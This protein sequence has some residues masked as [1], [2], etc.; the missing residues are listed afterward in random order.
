MDNK[1]RDLQI[2]ESK[3][4]FSKKDFDLLY[5]T[6]HKKVLDFV[7]RRVDTKEIA[8]DLTSEIFEKVYKFVDD[9]KWQGITISAWIFRIARNRIIDHYRKDNK[10][11]KNSS[12]DDYVNIIVSPAKE[13][14]E[15]ILEKE[16]Y[17]LL[18]DAIREF[19]EEDQYLI[20]YKF[21]EDLSNKEIAK[22]I[23]LSETNVGTRLHR[24]RT[25]LIKV[26]NKLQ[27]K[28]ITT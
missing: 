7:A 26:I 20:Y 3:K 28:K 9:F 18:Y 10:Y 5:K 11:K 24:L 14:E 16:E 22:L 12:I 21:F 1:D 6:F 25:K 23:K 27:R 8:E 19:N 15:L 4:E 2:V 13:A 17:I